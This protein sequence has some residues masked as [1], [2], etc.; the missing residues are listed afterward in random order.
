MSF[1]PL[2]FTITWESGGEAE[3]DMLPN[4]QFTWILTS[5]EILFPFLTLPLVVCGMVELSGTI[6]TYSIIITQQDPICSRFHQK[7][8]HQVATV[9]YHQVEFGFKD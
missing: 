7:S 1:F 4:Y 9:M 6:F 5:W 2:K 3:L 8:T